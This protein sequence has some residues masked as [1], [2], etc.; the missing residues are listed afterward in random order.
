MFRFLLQSY[1][2]AEMSDFL[3]RLIWLNN[4]W[5]CCSK[6]SLASS[7]SRF[8]RSSSNLI[9][10]WHFWNISELTFVSFSKVCFRRSSWNLKK[11]DS[12]TKSKKQTKIRTEKLDKMALKTRQSSNMIVI[13]LK[14]L[15][16]KRQLQCYWRIWTLISLVKKYLSSLENIN[17]VILV[18]YLLV[19]F[20]IVNICYVYDV[21]STLI[22]KTCTWCI[23]S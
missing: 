4:V 12:K 11:A 14:L 1:L 2:S 17:C 22:K 7:C 21:M 5:I 23:T 13:E 16:T 9:S 19:K 20:Q 18:V 8:W 15:K 6:M 10:F 3:R